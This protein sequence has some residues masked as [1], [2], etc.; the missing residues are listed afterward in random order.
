M[1]LT[2]LCVL[3]MNVSFRPGGKANIPI[4]QV[5]TQKN[6]DSSTRSLTGKVC[7]LWGKTASYWPRDLKRAVIDLAGGA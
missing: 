6:I 5:G 4:F 2:L 7:A 3:Q 1:N